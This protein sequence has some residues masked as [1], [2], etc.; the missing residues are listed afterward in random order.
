MAIDQDEEDNL[1]I[2]ELP[3]LHKS[4]IRWV[5]GDDDTYFNDTKGK[6]FINSTHWDFGW[7]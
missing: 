4:L 2:C 5:A 6:A 7:M 1:G 3:D